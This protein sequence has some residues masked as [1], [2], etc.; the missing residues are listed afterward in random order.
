MK[1][2]KK[3]ASLILVLVLV[4]SMTATVFAETPAIYSITIKNST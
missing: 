2:T 4:L 3:L 1:N